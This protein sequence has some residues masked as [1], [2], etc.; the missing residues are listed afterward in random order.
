MA[1]SSTF[2]GFLRFSMVTLPIRAYNATT[3][4]HAGVRMHQIHDKCGSRIRYQKTC[5][6]H[7]PVPKEQ[8]ASGYEYDKGQYVTFDPE[9][10]SKAKSVNDRVVTID[11]FVPGGL[12]DPAYFSGRTLYFVPSGPAGRQP[13]SLLHETMNSLQRWGIARLVLAGHD[14]VGVVRTIGK[15]LALTVLHQAKEVKPTSAFAADVEETRVSAEERHL[16]ETLVNASTADTFDLSGYVDHYAERLQKLVETKA[17]GKKVRSPADKQEPVILN[18][19]DALKK[20]LG[21]VTKEEKARPPRTRQNCTLHFQP[22][23]AE[24]DA[25]IQQ[26]KHVRKCWRALQSAHGTGEDKVSGR[27]RRQALEGLRHLIG[28]D[29]YRRGRMP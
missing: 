3:A 4:A 6:I 7:G 27:T 11:R 20:S 23:S 16:A 22:K 17:K 1:F 9:E 5:P 25:A 10:L 15:L 18:L 29:D 2:D 14:E 26:M 8:I 13:Y 12:V 28:D 24:R 21:A 19:M